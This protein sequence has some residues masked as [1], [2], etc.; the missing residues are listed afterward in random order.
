[1]FTWEQSP[2]WH[3]SVHK[4]MPQCNNFWHVPP[5]ESTCSEHGAIVFCF[6][7][8]Q[9]RG[10][11]NGQSPQLPVWQVFK[12]LCN[13]Q[14]NGLLQ[15]MSHN[16]ILEEQLRSSDFLPQRHFCTLRFLHGGHSVFAVWQTCPHTCIPHDKMCGH[17]L[18]QVHDF[19]E[20]LIVFGFDCS[21][22]HN[23]VIIC[24]HGGHG[25]G[26]Q[27]KTQR[28]PQFG[29]SNFLHVSPQEC[30]ISHGWNCGLVSF[31]QKHV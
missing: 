5:H 11:P 14:E 25:P 27:S 2:L 4:C 9:E 7:H 16:Q 23:F 22:L 28:C 20:H 19:C 30:G 21:H 26:W 6:P 31:P 8:G 17:F 13:P 12:H 1:M 24:G 3:R 18:E 29:C 10:R 15:T